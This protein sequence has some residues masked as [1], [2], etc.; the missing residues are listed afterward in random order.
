MIAA[1]EIASR[2][3]RKAAVNL[4]ELLL[5]C[6]VTFAIF[7]FGTLTRKALFPRAIVAVDRLAH[8]SARNMLETLEA[9]GYDSGD[10]EMI[11]EWLL[12]SI[13]PI[14]QGWHDWPF[15]ETPIDPWDNSYIL[16]TEDDGR[17]SKVSGLG[18]YSRGPD[19]KSDSRGNDLDDINTWSAPKAEYYD[20]QRRSLTHARL[21]R[22][23]IYAVLGAVFYGAACWA[24]Q[25]TKA[26]TSLPRRRSDDA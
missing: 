12:G 9:A 26:K 2:S 25:R 22:H 1:K 11:E 6:V 10:S 21:I 13:D 14:D 16:V 23:A 5:A 8:S 3:S 7:E 15:E 4:H 24:W 19:G 20:R 18:L 17:L